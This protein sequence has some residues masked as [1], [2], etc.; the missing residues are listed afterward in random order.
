MCCAAE[1]SWVQNVAAAVLFSG[2][3]KV[4]WVPHG[5]SIVCGMFI[6][7]TSGVDH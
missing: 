1:N 3:R 6:I 5:S 7:F 2:G 4:Q